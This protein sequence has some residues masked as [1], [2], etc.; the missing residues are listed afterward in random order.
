M[1]SYLPPAHILAIG[2]LIFGLVLCVRILVVGPGPEVAMPVRST[3]LLQRQLDLQQ[4]SNV[5]E[6]DDTQVDENR[7]VSISKMNDVGEFEEADDDENEDLPDGD[8]AAWEEVDTPPMRWRGVAYGRALDEDSGV[9]GGDHTVERFAAQGFEGPVLDDSWNV[10][11]THT[12]VSDWLTKHAAVLG[13]RSPKESKGRARLTNHCEYYKAAGDKCAFANHLSRVASLTGNHRRLRTF[14]LHNR[15]EYALWQDS[16]QKNPHKY[17]VVKDCTNGASQGIKLLVGRSVARTAPPPGT[18]AVAQEFL[19]N[20]YLGWG[21]HKFH[22]RLYVLATRWD[23]AGVFLFNDGLVFQ[24]RSK[25]QGRKP[26]L[27][28][29]I[30]SSVSEKVRPLQLEK[31]WRHIDGTGVPSKVVW[32]R[33][34]SLLKNV[35]GVGL[36]ESFGDPQRLS[37]RSFSCFDLFGVDV[38]LDQQLEP[39]VLEVN[40]GP[41]LW[42]DQEYETMQRKVKGSLLNEVAHWAQLRVQNQSVSNAEPTLEMKIAFEN[43]ALKTF[44][45]LL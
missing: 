45:R 42:L 24:S 14:E 29:D 39:Y 20:P 38:I 36:K 27:R 1:L 9:Y 16:A 21:G 19:S 37:K 22:M 40:I 10:L 32:A 30:F 25:Y 31:L 18:W 3:V 34:A 7:S 28:K 6:Y 41:N 15:H 5:T 13:S 33:V 12:P 44:Q 26:S 43:L 8:L 11:F 2:P 23:P 17:W 35:F 4:V